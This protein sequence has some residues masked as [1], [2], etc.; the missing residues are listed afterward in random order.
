MAF[1]ILNRQ[2]YDRKTI[3]RFNIFW[4]RA[5]IYFGLLFWAFICLFPIYWTILTSFKTEAQAI[6][7]PPLFFNFDW[8]LENY[9]VVQ[10]RSNYMRYL[11]NSIIIAGGSTLLGIII[12]VPAAWVLDRF[13]AQ[14]LSPVRAAVSCLSEAAQAEAS[15]DQDLGD[16]VDFDKGPLSDFQPDQLLDLLLGLLDTG[17]ILVSRGGMTSTDG[18]VIDDTGL[19]NEKLQE[20]EDFYNFNRPHGGLDGQTPTNG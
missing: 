3:R 16:L 5:F 12:A 2:I 10:E 18:V 17:H 19:F 20:W 13:G 1:S 8:T 15:P 14:G 9:A 4:I 6:N 7:D 11:W